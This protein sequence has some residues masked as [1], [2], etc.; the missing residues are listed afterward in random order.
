MSSNKP[1]EA[2]LI[3]RESEDSLLDIGFKKPK[4]NPM[5]NKYFD[6]CGSLVAGVVA[7]I[8]TDYGLIILSEALRRFDEVKK[9]RMH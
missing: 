9:K 7:M 8:K 4:T 5:S 2:I 3:L 1:R 6:V